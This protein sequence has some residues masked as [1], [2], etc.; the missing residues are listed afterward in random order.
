MAG[1]VLKFPCRIFSVHSFPTDCGQKKRPR[2]TESRW[3]N[4]NASFSPRQKS[5]KVSW[6]RQSKSPHFPRLTAPVL[7]PIKKT[8]QRGR[9]SGHLRFCLKFCASRETCRRPPFAVP[10]LLGTTGQR[11]SKRYRK[12][13]TDRTGV[14]TIG[15]SQRRGGAMT[16]EERKKFQWLCTQVTIER[17]P[18]K[19]DDY[20]REWND[21]LEPTHERIQAAAGLKH[22]S[23]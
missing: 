17:D 4:T 10:R 23:D 7:K 14:S 9:Q 13:G 21:L 22:N 15:F 6:G 5:Y 18:E 8:C 11:W 3:G 19:F 20:V 12:L 2:R 1:L 16:P